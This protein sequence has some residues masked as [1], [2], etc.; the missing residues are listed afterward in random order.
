MHPVGMF[1]TGEGRNIKSQLPDQDFLS[2]S[3]ENIDQSFPCQCKN[4]REGPFADFSSN[5]EVN[6]V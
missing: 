5:E 1:H 6:N 4:K 3:L 2:M